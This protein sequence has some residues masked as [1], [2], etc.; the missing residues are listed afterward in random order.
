MI[1]RM[2]IV[3]DVGDGDGD[4]GE[5]DMAGLGHVRVV[6]AIGN[7]RKIAHSPHSRHSLALGASPLSKFQHPTRD[8]TPHA[9]RHPSRLPPSYS[10]YLLILLFSTF[11]T[12]PLFQVAVALRIAHHRW[13]TSQER[14]TSSRQAN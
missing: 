4:E 1:W 11:S 7:S 9:T 8:H 6:E 14:A 13:P 10:I 12:F 5:A 2:G 3:T